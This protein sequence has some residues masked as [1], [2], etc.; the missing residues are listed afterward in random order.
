MN[1]GMKI[2]W[3]NLGM[4]LK[5][6]HKYIYLIQSIHMGMVRHNWAIQK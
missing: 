5:Y 3:I 1:L 6:M 4:K 2:I